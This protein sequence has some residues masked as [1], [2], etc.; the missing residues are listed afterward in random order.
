M[1]WAE[2]LKHLRIGGLTNLRMALGEFVDSSIRKFDNSRNASACVATGA[3]AEQTVH[4]RNGNA[5]AQ[6]GEGSLRGD[7]PRRDEKPRPRRPCERAADADAA[8]AEI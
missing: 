7:L 5:T 2:I 3:A 8:H 1:T 4:L 6:P